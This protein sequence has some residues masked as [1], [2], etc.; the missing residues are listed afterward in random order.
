MYH[1]GFVPQEHYPSMIQPSPY[2]YLPL[3]PGRLAESPNT[4]MFPPIQMHNF[5]SRPVTTIMDW[6]SHHDYAGNQLEYHH[7]YGSNPYFHPH[8]FW[9][10]SQVT[11]M[12]LYNPYANY[13]P[14]AAYQ[15]PSQG[16]DIWP[17]GF[18][19]RGELHWGKLERVFGPRR[20]LPEFVKED[21]RR[22]Y[23]TYPRTD[24]S[25]TFQ[26]R[27][28]LVKGDPRVG[29]QDYTVEKR[30]IRR[31]PTPTASEADDDSEERNRKKKK[32]SRR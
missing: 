7:F 24:V 29:E 28:F 12:S 15:R 21:L 27:E 32:K 16:Q 4:T 19:M 3:G 31:D 23:G 2:T 13:N 11:P 30:V 5:Y 8:P 9:H 1:Y 14:Y 17:Q 22:V 26:N 25:I 20:E 6:N 18:T 10:F